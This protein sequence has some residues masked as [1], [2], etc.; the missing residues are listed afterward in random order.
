MGYNDDGKDY[1][2]TDDGTI[3]CGTICL[4]PRGGIPCPEGACY[5]AQADL[6]ESVMYSD[7]HS[8]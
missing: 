6:I 2:I 8:Q 3:A 7:D 5:G 4:D 1:S